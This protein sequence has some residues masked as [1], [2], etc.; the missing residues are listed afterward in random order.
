MGFFEKKR[1]IVEAAS[2]LGYSI[3]SEEGRTVVLMGTTF[4]KEDLTTLEKVAKGKLEWSVCSSPKDS[5][6]IEIL[7]VIPY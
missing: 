5:T 7:L 3:V 2:K 1:K 4:K 6:R